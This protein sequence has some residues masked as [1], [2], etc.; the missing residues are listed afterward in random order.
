MDTFAFVFGYT[1]WGQKLALIAQICSRTRIN[2][3]SVSLRLALAVFVGGSRDN[4]MVPSSV[5]PELCWFDFSLGAPVL[6]H[7]LR[8]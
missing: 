1:L 7:Y 5:C 6:D 3:V 2:W 4:D 8:E